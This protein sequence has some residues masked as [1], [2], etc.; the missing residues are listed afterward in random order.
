MVLVCVGYGWAGRRIDQGKGQVVAREVKVSKRVLKINSI[1]VLP[2]NPGRKKK[3]IAYRISSSLMI[4]NKQQK[5]TESTIDC[6]V[7]LRNR[8]WAGV[9]KCGG[10]GRAATVVAVEA[11]SGGCAT[12][13]SEALAIT[14]HA[15]LQ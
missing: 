12:N 9:G 6:D 10:G 8:E 7:R 4:T 1:C 5:S 14:Q 13:Q 3:G 11:S 15:T 2:E